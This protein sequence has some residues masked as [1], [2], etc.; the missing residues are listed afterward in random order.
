VVVFQDKD[1]LLTSKDKEKIQQ[2]L[3]VK[4]SSDKVKVFYV[5]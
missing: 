4:L 5:N 2:W 1:G 3:S